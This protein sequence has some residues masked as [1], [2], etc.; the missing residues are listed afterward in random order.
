MG[1][2]DPLHSCTH[3]LLSILGA[4]GIFW[5]EHPSTELESLDNA[6]EAGSCG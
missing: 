2:A 1:E 6:Q 4:I 3:F 5:A